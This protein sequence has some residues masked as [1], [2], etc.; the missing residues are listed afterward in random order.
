MTRRI[1]ALKHDQR[2]RKVLDAFKFSLEV[3]RNKPEIRMKALISSAFKADSLQGFVA[4]GS[5]AEERFA[6]NGNPV[7]AVAWTVPGWPGR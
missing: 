1:D 3:D 7:V 6:R 5:I 2:G 4:N